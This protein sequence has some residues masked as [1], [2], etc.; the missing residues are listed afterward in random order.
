MLLYFVLCAF[1]LQAAK[2]F[3]AIGVVDDELFV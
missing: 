3:D 1:A 2:S